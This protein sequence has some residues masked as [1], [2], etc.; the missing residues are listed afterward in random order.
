MGGE[1][2]LAVGADVVDVPHDA[3]GAEVRFAAPRDV[4]SAVEERADLVHPTVARVALHP[5]LPVK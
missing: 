5:R 2:A 3:D 1:V 4:P